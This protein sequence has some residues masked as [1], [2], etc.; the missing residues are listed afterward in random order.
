MTKV[1]KVG[2]IVGILLIGIFMM[3]CPWAR[4]AEATT[5]AGTIAFDPP[6]T[7]EADVAPGKSG[8]VTLTGTVT[9]N[10]AMLGQS[11]QMAIVSL[12]ASCDQGWPVTLSPTTITL[13]PSKG[14]DTGYW[15]LTVKVPPRTPH[16]ISANVV[17]SGD[18]RV[19]PGQLVYPIQESKGLVTVKQFYRFSIFCSKPYI[20]VMPGSP[21]MF[22][23]T[24]KNEGNA[25][26]KFGFEV[27][28]QERYVRAGWSIQL[29]SPAIEIEEQ[30]EDNIKI[31]ITT[32][33]DWTIYKVELSE[34]KIR[35][36][37][38]QCL[39]N[40][41]ILKFE[42]YS[43]Y[44]REKGYYIPGFDPWFIIIALAGVA[45]V[46][47]RDTIFRRGRRKIR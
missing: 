32:P 17:V 31:S 43:I 28:N 40:E 2:L 3:V 46:L 15:S 39:A 47:K 7:A 30:Q 27:T 45:V 1:L 12:Q 23:I 18:A 4:V 25:L 6:A 13:D 33:L 37:S 41:Q 21:V 14:Q 24:I 29:S 44:V 11:I 38:K 16:K 20:V 10:E 34:F 26:D 42:D 19:F 9:V 36:I 5:Y 35:V 8:L 22:T